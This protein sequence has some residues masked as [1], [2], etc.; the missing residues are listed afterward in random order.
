MD[1]MNNCQHLLNQ[2]SDNDFS[3]YSSIFD[4]EFFINIM[5][6]N[7]TH[8]AEYLQDVDAFVNGKIIRKPVLISNIIER[9]FDEI[10]SNAFEYSTSDT[11]VLN[12]KDDLISIENDCN[13]RNQNINDSVNT[14][15]E[16]FFGHRNIKYLSATS[17]CYIV[18]MI[19]EYFKVEL[20]DNVTGIFQEI[21]WTSDKKN[22]IS[23][24]T[25][26]FVCIDGNYVID[27]I[28]KYTGR[29]FIRV[30]WKPHTSITNDIIEF[31]MAKCAHLSFIWRKQVIFN[32]I[33]IDFYDKNEYIKTISD[34]KFITYQNDGIGIIYCDT[35]GKGRVISS[36]NGH[37]TESGV[38][39]KEAYSALLNFLS[40]S[41]P[42]ITLSK[43]KRDVTIIIKYT[44]KDPIYESPSKKHLESPRPTILLQSF[45][46]EILMEWESFRC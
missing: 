3:E 28:S 41:I 19:S 34:G 5:K 32:D 21:E 22:P 20:G 7:L 1:T 9:C 40:E 4:K 38:H 23:K 29:N 11:I 43:I 13:L 14:V 17:G 31:F 16:L 39:V 44:C 26:E 18:N 8:F 10:I 25:P 24:F 45:F 27:K 2:S 6:N 30:T 15:L 33:S 36:V 12:I 42:N 37:L 35:P 46:S